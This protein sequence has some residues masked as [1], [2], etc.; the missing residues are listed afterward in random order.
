MTTSQ[1]CKGERRRADVR[2]KKLFGLDF[3]EVSDD[4]LSLS[5]T[6][7]G[8]APRLNIKPQQLHIDGGRR[9]RNIQVTNVQMQREKNPEFDDAM[10]VTV[11]KYGDFSTYTLRVVG[12]D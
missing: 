6:F 12:I 7:L 11:D 4:Q 9:V 1:I 2:G 5:V 3:L 10:T 8:K